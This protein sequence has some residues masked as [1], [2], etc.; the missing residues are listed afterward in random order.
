MGDEY[1]VWMDK[2]LSTKTLSEITEK[3]LELQNKSDMS[4]DDRRSTCLAGRDGLG[5]ADQ[6]LVVAQA[7]ITVEEITE[8]FLFLKD[9]ARAVCANLVVMYGLDIDIEATIQIIDDAIPLIRQD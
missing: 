4:L 8:D 7:R 1:Q 3:C 6:A 5:E 9:R 2:P